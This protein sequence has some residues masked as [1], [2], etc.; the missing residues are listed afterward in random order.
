MVNRDMLGL[1]P[2]EARWDVDRCLVC[3]KQVARKVDFLPEGL[4]VCPSC[5]HEAIRAYCGDSV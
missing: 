1:D 3:E 5:I 4:I 2:E